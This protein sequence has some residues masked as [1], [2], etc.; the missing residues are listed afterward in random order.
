M[1][2][3]VD[4]KTF[5]LTDRQCFSMLD[6]AAEQPQKGLVLRAFLESIVLAALQPKEALLLRARNVALAAD[7]SGGLLMHPQGQERRVTD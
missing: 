7:G 1:A 3:V 4:A 2:A 6:W 5:R